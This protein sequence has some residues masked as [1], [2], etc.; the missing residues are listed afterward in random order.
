MN[1][2]TTLTGKI[3]FH[4]QI[5]STASTTYNVGNYRTLI[6]D[7]FGTSSSRTINFK[8]IGVSGTPYPLSGVRLSDL[9]VASSTSSTGETWSFDV[10]G[11][12]SVGIDV[13]AISGG[14]VSV[15]GRFVA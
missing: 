6:I 7:I 5:T 14:D 10:T 8:S 11:L 3:A 2:Y 4:D 15:K 1:Q 9:T 12:D 13:S